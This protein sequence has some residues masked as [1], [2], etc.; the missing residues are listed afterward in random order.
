MRHLVVDYLQ[1]HPLTLGFVFVMGFGWGISAQDLDNFSLGFL[2]VQFILLGFCGFTIDPSEGTRGVLSVLPI[3]SRKV[4]KTY[5]F[6]W[7]FVGPVAAYGGYFPG[8][9]MDYLSGSHPVFDG[10]MLVFGLEA[11]IYMSSM[12]WSTVAVIG[13]PTRKKRSKGLLGSVFGFAWLGS[14]FIPN[15]WL[16]IVCEN[17]PSSILPVI[18]ICGVVSF[19]VSPPV[20]IS[21]PSL[22][23]PRERD[24]SDKSVGAPIFFPSLRAIIFH[25]LM[26][27]L[28]FATV[29]MGILCGLFIGLDDLFADSRNSVSGDN[30]DRVSNL[31]IKVAVIQLFLSLFRD[32]MGIKDYLRGLRILPLRTNLLALVMTI[33]PLDLWIGLGLGSTIVCVVLDKWTLLPDFLPVVVVIGSVSSMFNAMIIGFDRNWD[34]D[35]KALRLLVIYLGLIAVPIGVFFAGQLGLWGLNVWMNSLLVSVVSLVLAYAVNRNSL[36]HNSDVYHPR[37]I[38]GEP[39]QAPRW[40]AGG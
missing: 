28:L 38:I 25:S 21:D 35:P 2:L 33:Y 10:R 22:S 11:L 18:L 7:V 12:S 4:M 9:L 14:F 8:T 26:N 23:R 20:L 3:S 19:L 31:I 30:T 36:F 40:Q 27:R 39:Q 29:G 13:D 16:K 17:A 24:T 32:G 34:I 1:R 37:A 15:E 6:I 5:W